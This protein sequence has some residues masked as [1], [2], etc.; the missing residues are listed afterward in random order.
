VREEHAGE[1]ADVLRLQEVEL[2]E[3]LD[4]AL[5][6]ALGVVHP[7]RDLALEIEGQPVLGALGDRVQ[8]AADRQQEALGAAEA[9]RIPRG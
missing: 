8:V 3:P 1:V 7:P 6:R 5:A 2:H 9:C 4:R